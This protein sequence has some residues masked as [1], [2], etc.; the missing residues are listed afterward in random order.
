VVRPRRCQDSHYWRCSSLVFNYLQLRFLYYARCSPQCLPFPPRW[1]AD[2]YTFGI[3]DILQSYNIRKQGEEFI[4]GTLMQ[5]KGTS[6]KPPPE[7][8]ERFN[9]FV[10]KHTA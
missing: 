1:H 9:L 5:K 3:I 2:R 4:K 7:Y 6:S 8:A 10:E